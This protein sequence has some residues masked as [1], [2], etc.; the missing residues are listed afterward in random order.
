M[1]PAWTQAK[2]SPLASQPSRK[3]DDERRQQTND[4]KP[5]N[6]SVGSVPRFLTNDH[7]DIES[8][9]LKVPDGKLERLTEANGQ[10]WS[11]DA[12]SM[13]RLELANEPYSE[14]DGS[15][16]QLAQANTATDEPADIN[17]KMNPGHRSIEQ[18]AQAAGL[19]A[20]GDLRGSTA[21]WATIDDHEVTNDFAGGHRLLAIPDLM[22]GTRASS[23]T[24]RYTKTD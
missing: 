15:L 11:D 21:L 4:K 7:I 23:M 2:Q 17:A 14:R 8:S 12:E 22:L 5:V 20:L 19:N 10:A 3:Y 1:A 18:Y 16:V 9:G 6:S 24:Q 13:R